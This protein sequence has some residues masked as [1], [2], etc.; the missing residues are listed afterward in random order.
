M[1]AL[2]CSLA[3][4][5]FAINSKPKKLKNSKQCTQQPCKPGCMPN[6]CCKKSVC[7]KV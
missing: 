3:T 6:G 2:A 5:T 1:L 7:G 4:G